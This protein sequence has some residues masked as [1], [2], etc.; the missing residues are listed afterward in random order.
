MDRNIIRK[1]ATIARIELHENEIEQLC[2]EMEK[3]LDHFSAIQE[4]KAERIEKITLENP[5][6]EDEVKRTAAEPIVQQFTKR[7]EKH[8]SAPKTML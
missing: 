4:L 2:L 5:L 6:R 8:L 3:I 7:E 1:I